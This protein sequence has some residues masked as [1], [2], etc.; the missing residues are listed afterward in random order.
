MPMFLH[1][2]SNNSS[3]S[4]QSM[5]SECTVGS[6]VMARGDRVLASGLLV[7]TSFDLKLSITYHDVVLFSPTFYRDRNN[8][9]HLLLQEMP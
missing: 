2:V 9:S 1:D 6:C 5:R 7:H 4:C 3:Q 8:I